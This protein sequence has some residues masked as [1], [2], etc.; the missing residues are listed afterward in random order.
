MS[1]CWTIPCG[2]SNLNIRIY[3]IWS[4]LKRIIWWCSAYRKIQIT[5]E[6]RIRSTNTVDM[7]LVIIHDE[8]TLDTDSWQITKTAD[9]IEFRFFWI[10]SAMHV[11]YHFEK[12]IIYRLHNSIVFKMCVQTELFNFEPTGCDVIIGEYTCVRSLVS[13]PTFASLNNF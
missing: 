6:Q 13:I 12:C 2:C 7:N 3:Q 1:A 11:S 8:M 10:P 9:L 5:H 4:L